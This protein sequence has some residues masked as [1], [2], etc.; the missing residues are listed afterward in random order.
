[1]LDNWNDSF[2]K[3]QLEKYGWQKYG[4]HRVKYRKDA[5]CLLEVK[6]WANTNMA[7][8]STLL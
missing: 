2:A 6:A 1:M 4:K 8:Q 5:Y 7:T 3:G